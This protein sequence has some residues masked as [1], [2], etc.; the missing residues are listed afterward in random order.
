MSSIIRRI[1]QTP[2]RVKYFLATQDYEAPPSPG[3]VDPGDSTLVFIDGYPGFI[4]EEESVSANYV[5]FLA[6]DLL[7]DLG[8]EVVTVNSSGQR[9]ARYREVQ[10]VNGPTSEG[11]GDKV[12]PLDGD[13][14]CFF[15]KV[16]SADGDG[17]YVVRTG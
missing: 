13:Y 5:S 17:V 7:K 16:W 8:R 2:A 12:D 10:R 6:G 15:V 3:Y 9:T 4:V 1:P 14:G 11:V